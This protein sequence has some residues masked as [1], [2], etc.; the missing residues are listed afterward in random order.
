MMK[1][2]RAEV[3]TLLREFHELRTASIPKVCRKLFI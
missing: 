1:D 2:L 3:K